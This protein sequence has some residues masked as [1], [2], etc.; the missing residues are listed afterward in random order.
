M[1]AN[2]V[3]IRSLSRPLARRAL[4]IA[5]VLWCTTVLAA[6]ELSPTLSPKPTEV[7][8]SAPIAKAPTP[9]CTESKALSSPPPLPVKLT[10]DTTSDKAA[11]AYW[12]GRKLIQDGKFTEAVKQFTEAVLLTPTLAL[13]FNGRAYANIRRKLFSEALTDLD[14]AL[15][16]N[17]YYANAYQNRSVAKRHLGDRGG[18]DADLAKA[19]ELLLALGQSSDSRTNT[20]ITSIWPVEGRVTSGFGRRID[21][22]SG[23]GAFHY[24]IDIDAQTG[25]PVRS[26]ADGIVIH[27]GMDTGGYGRLVVLDHG[28]G[29]QTWYAHLSLIKVTVGQDVRRGEVIGAAGSS[30]HATAPH[31]HYEVRVGGVPRDPYLYLSRHLAGHGKSTLARSERLTAR[32]AVK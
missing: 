13:A 10:P 31:L 29:T 17:P 27:E 2:A 24:G 26:T 21:P 28:D 15:K 18:A 12:L 9:K 20:A 1:A 6:A 7:A 19:K 4:V 32:A 25:D 5:V 3:P 14:Q 16:L 11:L 30:G 8:L 23:E 22:F